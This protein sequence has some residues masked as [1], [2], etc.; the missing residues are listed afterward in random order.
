MATVDQTTLKVQRLLTGAMGLR[1]TLADDA[2]WIRFEDAS[3]AV[4]VTVREWGTD[5]D[6]EPRTLVLVD[7]LIL[8][9]VPATPEL[10]EFIARSGGG[11]WFGHI[12]AFDGAAPDTV[13]L[14]MCHS[15]LGDYLDEEE[16]RTAVFSILAGADALDDQ[17]QERFGGHRFVDA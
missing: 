4:R 12:Q 10:F 5:S 15:L 14:V 13:N 9:E 1:L 2:F 8:S 7:S 11:L 3:T 6:G 17:L 16:L